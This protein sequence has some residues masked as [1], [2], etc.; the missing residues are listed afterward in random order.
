MENVY[1]GDSTDPFSNLWL[2][3]IIF[4]ILFGICLYNSG[5][6]QVDKTGV[7]AGI[8][9]GSD[10]DDDEVEVHQRSCTGISILW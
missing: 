7:R 9:E 4:L 10:S 1:L 8:I 5:C 2:L 6:V 3:L